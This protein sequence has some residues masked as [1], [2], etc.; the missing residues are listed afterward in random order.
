[1]LICFLADE[2]RLLFWS[3]VVLEEAIMMSKDHARRGQRES[4]VER[5]EEK[6]WS[7][8]RQMG[9]SAELELDKILIRIPPL[10]PFGM[11]SSECGDSWQP[12]ME[13]R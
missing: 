7:T 11:N 2:G 5:R 6:R 3:P 9:W 12:E 13:R 10:A 1:M 4:H 8:A